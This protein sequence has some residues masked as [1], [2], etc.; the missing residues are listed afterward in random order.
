MSAAPSRRHLIVRASAELFMRQGYRDTSIRQI[1]GAVGCTDA[2][3]Y[4]HFP[5]GKQELLSVVIE[6]CLPDLTDMLRDCEGATSVADLLLR[7]SASAS[8]NQAA[9]RQRLTWVATEFPRLSADE[10]RLLHRKQIA[11]HDRLAALLSP[12]LAT[13]AD[14]DALAWTLLCAMFGYG[15]LFWMLDLQSAVQFTEADFTHQ[16]MRAFTTA[17]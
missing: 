3:L 9:R 17:K 5:R 6:E 2:A 1:A 14:A 8:Q 15:F 10:R 13:E 16:M 7:L 11:L 12:F 4:Y